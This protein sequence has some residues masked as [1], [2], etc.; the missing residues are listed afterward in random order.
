MKISTVQIE[1]AAG[2]IANA[3]GNRR[4]MPSLSNI[5]EI[6][7]PKLRDE[8]MEDAKAALEAAA[9]ATPDLAQDA[10][11]LC[12]QIEKCGASEELTQASLMASELRQKL[13]GQ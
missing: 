7:S 3:R 12:W 5:L 1:A 2:A 11:E 6:L 10:L 4:G 13:A 9:A 8:V